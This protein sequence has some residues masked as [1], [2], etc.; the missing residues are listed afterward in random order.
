MTGQWFAWGKVGALSSNFSLKAAKT[1]TTT[2]TAT[3]TTT[4]CAFFAP[5]K[6]PSL[7]RKIVLHSLKEIQTGNLWQI[8]SFIDA[9]AVIQFE[10]KSL[11]KNSIGN[12]GCWVVN[13]IGEKKSLKIEFN[14]QGGKNSK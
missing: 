5:Q 13:L 4:F 8:F 10:K 6:T 3:T 11:T 1:S 7:E 9:A 2:T 12:S 14:Y